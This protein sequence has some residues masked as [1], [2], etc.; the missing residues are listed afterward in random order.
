MAGIF[1]KPNGL[2]E[3]LAVG[4][5]QCTRKLSGIFNITK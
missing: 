3:I 5:M 2:V 4:L 1:G